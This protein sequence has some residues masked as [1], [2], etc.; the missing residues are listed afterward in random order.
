MKNL[1]KEIKGDKSLWERMN[2]PNAGEMLI[3]EESY[4]DGIIEDLEKQDK[5]SL[6]NI[7]KMANVIDINARTLWSVSLGLFSNR[8]AELYERIKEVNVGDLVTETSSAFAYP[9]I[10]RVGYLKSIIESE[11]SDDGWRHYI[12]EKLDGKTMDWSNCKFIKVL[13]NFEHFI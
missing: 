12:I 9:A 5:Q 4:Y 2:Y 10:N 13:T 3:V 7:E 6:E 1:A 11:D 8:Q